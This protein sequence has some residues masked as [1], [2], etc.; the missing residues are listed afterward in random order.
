MLPNTLPTAKF[1]TDQERDLAIARQCGVEHGTGNQ[2]GNEKFSLKEVRR[3]FMYPLTWLTACAYFGLLSSIYSIGLFLPTIIVKLGY[4]A[5]E[6]QLM[7]VPPYAVA[8]VMT[9]VVAFV[10]DRLKVRG[11]MMLCTMP[12]A[13]VGYAV[14]ANIHDDHP[15][16]KYGMT[17][18][19]ATGVYSSVPPVLA[20]LSNNSAGHYKRATAA[21]LQLAVANCGGILSVFLYPDSDASSGFYR[22]H[23]VILGLLVVGWFL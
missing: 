22:G 17:I 3:A 16:V 11:V 5:N 15:K 7:S 18:M 10:S 9:L 1:L 20:W 19:M 2:E 6:A 12:V 21:A 23:S 4:T 14:I 8:A 13:I